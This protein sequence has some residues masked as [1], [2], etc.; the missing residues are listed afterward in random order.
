MEEGSVREARPGPTSRGLSTHTERD[1]GSGQG[2]KG[3]SLSGPKATSTGLSVPAHPTQIAPV[4]DL[5]QP[6]FLNLRLAFKPCPTPKCPSPDL[7]PGLSPNPKSSRVPALSSSLTSP[8]L[9]AS[10]CPPVPPLP[11]IPSHHPPPG[12]LDSQ[13]WLEILAKKRLPRG[14]VKVKPNCRWLRAVSQEK[15]APSSEQGRGT[16]RVMGAR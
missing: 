9:A 12:P 1:S 7:A 2:R 11:L 6:P 4:R 13:V 15:Q 5:A 8:G 16:P 3:D 10:P 14:P